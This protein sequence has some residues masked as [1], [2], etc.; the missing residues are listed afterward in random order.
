MQ[1]EEKAYVLDAIRGIYF[2]DAEKPHLGETAGDTSMMEDVITL[3]H[4]NVTD[5]QNVT[6]TSESS[7]G[8]STTA[9][10]S[11]SSTST[12]NDS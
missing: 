1:N 2:D 11:S 5:D 7:S 8:L 3:A 9:N 6:V 4:L 10:E 12:L